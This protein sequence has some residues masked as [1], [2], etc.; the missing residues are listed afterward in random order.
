MDWIKRLIKVVGNMMSDL[1]IGSYRRNSDYY[2]EQA[3]SS[4]NK[5]KYYAFVIIAA[6]VT[7]GI[8]VFVYN[9]KYW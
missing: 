7:V 2:D 8:I 5:P 4:E 6:V 1:W 3:P 9:P